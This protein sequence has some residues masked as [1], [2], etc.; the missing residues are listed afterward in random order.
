[1]ITHFL[2]CW[3]KR[4]KTIGSGLLISRK[5]NVNVGF[6]MTLECEKCG[7]IIHRQFGRD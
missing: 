3:P 6:H 4:W 7:W 5:N 2:F 1:M